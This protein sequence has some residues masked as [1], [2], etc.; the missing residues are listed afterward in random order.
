MSEEKKCDAC[1]GD[2]CTTCGGCGNC[3]TCKCAGAEDPE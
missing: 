1:G 2:T 3:G